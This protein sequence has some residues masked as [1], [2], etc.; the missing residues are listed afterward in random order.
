MCAR[1]AHRIGPDNLPPSLTQCN[2]GHLNEAALVVALGTPLP[3][4]KLL[5][6]TYPPS[7][8][9][10]ASVHALLQEIGVRLE[11]RFGSFEERHLY[12]R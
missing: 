3:Y 5:C 11:D 2:K 1:V 4:A 9:A 7:A 12:N 6:L 8:K 10:R